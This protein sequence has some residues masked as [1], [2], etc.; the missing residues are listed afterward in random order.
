MKSNKHNC[1]KCQV[2]Y[3]DEDIE[4]YYCPSCLIESKRIAAE[5]DKKMADRPKKEVKGHFSPKDF[6]GIGGRIFFNHKDI[7]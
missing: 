2:E 3:S 7:L 5:I 4:N 1:I 6:I